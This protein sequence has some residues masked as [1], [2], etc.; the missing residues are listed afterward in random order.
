MPEGFLDFATAKSLLARQNMN[1]LVGDP[2]TPFKSGPG[3]SQ[4]YTVG[5]SSDIGLP[6]ITAG[7]ARS[8]VVVNGANVATLCR[9]GPTRQAG[10][11]RFRPRRAVATDQFIDRH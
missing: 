10:P 4:P 1:G 9:E 5:G 6:C 3:Y 11:R 8:S 2:L 7:R